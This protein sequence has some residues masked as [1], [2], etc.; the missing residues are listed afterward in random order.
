M[1]Y[2]RWSPGFSGQAAMAL[3]AGICAVQ[4]GC[5]LRST[6]RRA[7]ESGSDAPEHKPGGERRADRATNKA[8]AEPGAAS[9][10]DKPARLIPKRL[11]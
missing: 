11:R 7:A 1:C 4:L 10:A 8:V 2:E 6:L 5:A 3:P 9:H